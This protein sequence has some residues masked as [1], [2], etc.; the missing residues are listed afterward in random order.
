MTSQAFLIALSLTAPAPLAAQ[1]EQPRRP[2][3]PNERRI[4]RTLDTIGTRLGR[5]VRCMTQAEWEQFTRESG[6]V[7]DRMQR[8]AA[9]CQPWARC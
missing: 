4:C 2:M 7:V 8:F 5:V 1:A 9:P 6:Q 3:D